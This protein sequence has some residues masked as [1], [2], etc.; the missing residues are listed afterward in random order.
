MIFLLQVFSMVAERFTRR[1]EHEQEKGKAQ[2]LHSIP[3]ENYVS[4]P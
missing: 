1:Q 4:K 2:T 3:L